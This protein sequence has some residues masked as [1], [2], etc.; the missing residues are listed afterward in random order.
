MEDLRYFFVAHAV[1]FDQPED[2]LAL[3]GKGG[4]GLVHPEMKL[5]PFEFFLRIERVE[6]VVGV[7]LPH[8]DHVIMRETFQVIE[9]LVLDGYKEVDF[10]VL[11]SPQVFAVQPAFDEDIRHHL[12]GGFFAAD[13]EQA[14][15]HQPGIATGEKLFKCF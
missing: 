15:V 8:A 6:H 2:H 12:F 7:E 3:V 5:A 9:C 1:F 11:Y 14:K 4:D 10:R 13:I